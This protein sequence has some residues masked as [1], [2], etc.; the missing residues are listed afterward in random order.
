MVCQNKLD[1]H[2]HYPFGSAN[3]WDL[4]IVQSHTSGMKLE[5]RCGYNKV[6]HCKQNPLCHIICIRWLLLALNSLYGV[7][8]A[9]AISWSFSLMISY[10]TGFLSFLRACRNSMTC[11]SASW[12]LYI[13][14]AYTLCKYMYSNALYIF[15]QHHK[16]YCFF[17]QEVTTSLR[18]ALYTF[19]YLPC[20]T[21]SSHLQI[22][23]YFTQIGFKETHKTVKDH[24]GIFWIT[25]HHTTSQVTEKNS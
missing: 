10:I 24:C 22:I 15:S 23:C 25:V 14:Y 1:S 8:Y 16:S 6:P 9:C 5:I 18:Y 7:F 17:P 20:C 2:L 12:K 19:W 13:E 21:H 4:Y 11:S 3:N